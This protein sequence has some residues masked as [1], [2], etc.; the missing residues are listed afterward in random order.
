[1]GVRRETFVLLLEVL[2]CIGACLTLL[3][4]SEC[5]QVQ[6]VAEIMDLAFSF[7]DVV[8]GLVERTLL[9]GVDFLDSFVLEGLHFSFCF[10]LLEVSFA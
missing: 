3:V 6:I 8:T 4:E 2:F 1:V 9:L 5:E 10:L 7:E